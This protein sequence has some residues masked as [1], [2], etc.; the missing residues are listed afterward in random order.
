MFVG[1]LRFVTVFSCSIIVLCVP[2]LAH[3]HVWVKA[4]SELMHSPD[5]AVIA[6]RHAWSFNK[7][8]SASPHKTSRRI[9]GHAH[10][11]RASAAGRAECVIAHQSM[12]SFI[13]HNA[14]GASKTFG[15]K[16]V[17]LLSVKPY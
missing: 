14:R 1:V 9:K 2:A 13:S 12:R 4:K 10:P 16:S 17:S 6:V 7:M 11:R 15:V 3:P 5:G 8:F